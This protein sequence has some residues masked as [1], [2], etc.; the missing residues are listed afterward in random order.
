MDVI[1]L[2]GGLLYQW[3][4]GR[5]VKIVP[6]DGITVDEVHISNGLQDALI[7]EPYV[8]E[9]EIYANIPNI[10]LQAKRDVSVYVVMY[11][12]SGEQTVCSRPLV[13]NGRE[14]PAD[15][16]Y[17]EV[18]L[19]NYE[20]LEKRITVLEDGGGAA[21]AVKY[22]EQELTDEQRAQAREFQSTLPQGERLGGQSVPLYTATFQS[23]LPQGERPRHSASKWRRW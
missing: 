18:E 3:D 15:Y 14:K 13:V 17:T 21:D 12:E 23:T 20:A 11:N 5:K 4:T 8:E 2:I 10:L 19:K 7:V 1:N 9:G 22:T 6:R 16:V